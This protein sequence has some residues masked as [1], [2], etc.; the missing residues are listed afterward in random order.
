MCFVA[1]PDNALY[2]FV[3]DNTLNI[4]FSRPF[5]RY[6]HKPSASYTFKLTVIS[7]ELVVDHCLKIVVKRVENTEKISVYIRIRIKLG[8]CVGY[9]DFY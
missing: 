8:Q 2:N 7:I 5:K 4:Y 1:Q 9:A 3:D 6:K